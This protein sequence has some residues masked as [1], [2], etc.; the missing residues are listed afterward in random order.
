[1][2]RPR[3]F[4]IFRPRPRLFRPLFR[5]FRRHGL[6]RPGQV[7]RSVALAW[8]GLLTQCSSCS[9]RG[10]KVQVHPVGG[11]VKE[12]G[13]CGR[14]LVAGIG[15]T[16]SHE[17]RNSPSI[18]N[19]LGHCLKNGHSTIGTDSLPRK[20]VDRRNGFDHGGGDSEGGRRV[21]TQGKPLDL[22]TQQAR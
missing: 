6:F 18:R 3:L 15:D 2:P 8:P 4:R 9:G 17:R 10:S 11:W 12:E 5:L 22:L 14:A 16:R 1:M 21:P 7:P 19:V 20:I 13:I